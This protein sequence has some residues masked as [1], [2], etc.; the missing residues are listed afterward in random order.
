MALKTK[1]FV[2]WPSKDTIL[3]TLLNSFKKNYPNCRRIIDCTEIR[4]EQ[5]RT[6]EQRVYMY[7]RYKSSYTIKVLVAITPNGMISFLSKCYGGRSSDSFITNDS[8][9]LNLLEPGD[10]VLADKG[11][12]GIRPGCEIQTVFKLCLPF[13][14]ME[15]SLKMKYLI[16]I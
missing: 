11:F 3:A 9:F 6:V 1:D 16:H 15:N 8:G 14:I 2:F 5:P 4:T 12:P 10:I 13:Y 7:S